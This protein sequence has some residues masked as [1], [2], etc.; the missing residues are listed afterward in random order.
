ME[1]IYHVPS[2]IIKIANKEFTK[3]DMI[4]LNINC[5]AECDEEISEELER[6]LNAMKR[7]GIR[8]LGVFQKISNKCIS[9]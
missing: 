5:L 3:F 4:T 9:E 7:N 1:K 8:I 6:K 2:F